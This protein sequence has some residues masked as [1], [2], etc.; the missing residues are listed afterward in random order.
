MPS[1]HRYWRS[2]RFANP[3]RDVGT[4]YFLDDGGGGGDGG[5]S[6][7]GKVSWAVAGCHCPFTGWR[8]LDDGF[9][10]RIRYFL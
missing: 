6:K 2:R 1:S 4:V 7:T 3:S 8:G 9:F 10:F 5:L